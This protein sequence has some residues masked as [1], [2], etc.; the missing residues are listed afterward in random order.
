MTVSPGISQR[1]KIFFV[2]GIWKTWEVVPVVPFVVLDTGRSFVV[3]YSKFYI[4]T[5]NCCCL[6][7]GDDDEVA[8][9]IF[10][11]IFS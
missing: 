3:S 11:T 7:G 9:A 6:L 10:L 5:G 4:C 8:K 2:T 1:C